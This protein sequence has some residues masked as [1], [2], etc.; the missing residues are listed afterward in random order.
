MTQTEGQ[1]L[2]RAQTLMRHVLD[3][4]KIPQANLERWLADYADLQK[5]RAAEA[6]QLSLW[7]G[8]E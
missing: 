4:P 2:K 8:K 3:K 1:L 5:A 6:K 7:N